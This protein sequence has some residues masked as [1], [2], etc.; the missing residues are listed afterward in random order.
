MAGR[1]Q[2]RDESFGSSTGMV[3]NGDP[4]AFATKCRYV[5]ALKSRPE[6]IVASDEDLS[7]PVGVVE[8]PPSTLLHDA[9]RFRA[10]NHHPRCTDRWANP[11]WGRIN[12]G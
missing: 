9:E 2:R 6:N 12:A 8:R 3:L 4:D 1:L 7:R 11:P 10:H 5:G